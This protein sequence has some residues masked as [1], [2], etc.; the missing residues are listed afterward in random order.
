MTDTHDTH[1]PG[2]PPANQLMHAAA[3][4]PADY[5]E[6]GNNTTA[7]ATS[8]LWQQVQQVF[9]PN[10]V[11]AQARADYRPRADQM[12]MAQAIAHAISTN[13]VVVVE[14]GTGVGKTFAYLVPALLSGERVLVSTATKTLQ[15]QLFARD[16][17]YL[18]KLLGLPV[19]IALLKGRSSYLCL[20]RLALARQHP[21]MYGTER[22]RTLARI[23]RF[24]Q[25]TTS[26]D[27]AELS[28]LEER[29]P[30]IPIVTSTRENCLGSQCPQ[31]KDCHVNHA[32]RQALAADIVVINHHLFFADLAVRESGMAELLPSVH[33]VVFDEAHQLNAIG[34]Q[35][36]GKQL[37]TGHFFEFSR[38]LL[39]GGLEHA[40][41]LAEWQAISQHIEQSARNWRLVAAELAHGKWGWHGQAPDGLDATQW[42]AALQALSEAV[43]QAHAA[44]NTVSELAP[45]LMRLQERASAL[46][47]RIALFCQPRPP[48]T[49]RWM[50]VSNSLRL[51]QSPLDIAAT[52]RH[53]LLRLPAD[54]NMPAHD[55]T[56]LPHTQVHAQVHAHAQP[57]HEA[58]PPAPDETDET[59]EAGETAPRRAWIFTSATLG[60]EPQLR[61]FTEPCGLHGMLTLQVASP[62]DY[63]SRASL[64]IP[65][66]VPPNDPAH[67][68]QVAQLAAEG[69]QLLGGRTLVL[70]T[71]LRSLRLIGEHL[72]EHFGNDSELDILVQGESTKRRLTE[73]FRA[74]SQHSSGRGCVLVASTS[75]WE[76]VDIPGDAL[77]LV[78][79]DKLPFP[80]PN[81]PVVQAR[82]QRLKSQGRNAFMHYHLP[83]AAV[84]L[85]QG[86]GRLIRH[87]NDRGTL[88]ICDSRLRSMSYGAHLLAALPPMQRLPSHADF[89][90]KLQELN[91]LRA[92]TA[93]INTPTIDNQAPNTQSE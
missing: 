4:S 38:D 16:L 55:A 72:R 29:S 87:E 80:P 59:G 1:S 35:F 37:G 6:S 83:E 36:L 11:L 54:N 2:Q 58:S 73:R 86:A 15:D 79:I 32:R 43:A 67:P 9:A 47:E 62:F 5:S 30:I 92:G 24:A 41:G 65:A 53:T 14:A 21:D 70:T 46:L 18:C 50:D 12:R 31:Y 56:R 69:A 57:H 82:A 20:H 22:L 71:T 49:V 8:S 10:G 90:R 78:V 52:V 28:G 25:T 51:A 74:G 63:A 93:S 44:L 45:D 89:V 84:V 64:F 60:A 85:K 19:R 17:P 26:G 76:G 75:F 91:A 61:W 68:T 33:T 66:I 88:V 39:A 42:Q 23:E 81:D 3:P 7:D 48:E 27:L 34:V 40:R 13:G 77:Q